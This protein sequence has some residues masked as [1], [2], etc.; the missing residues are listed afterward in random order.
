M[1]VDRRNFHL[2]IIFKLANSNENN[3]KIDLNVTHISRGDMLDFPRF[4]I[5][6]FGFLEID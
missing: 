5:W 3:T 2:V 4:R 6:M 1:A